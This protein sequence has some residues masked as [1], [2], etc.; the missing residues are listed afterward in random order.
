MPRRR[1]VADTVTPETPA[2]GSVAPPGTV[3][4]NVKAIVVPTIAPSST[5]TIDRSSSNT[6]RLAAIDSGLGTGSPNPR[7]STRW[8]SSNSSSVMARRSTGIVLF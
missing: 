3:M 2:T 8:N 6:A 5:A 4:A 7:P 1:W